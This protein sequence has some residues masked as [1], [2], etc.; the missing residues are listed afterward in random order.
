MELGKR[1]EWGGVWRS[2]GEPSEPFLMTGFGKKALHLE[3]APGGIMRGEVDFLGDGTWEKYEDLNVQG[4]KIHVFPN[5]FSAH[6]VRL[7]ALQAGRA[8]AEF[9]Y[10]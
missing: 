1:A 7:T 6:W 10:T 8:T 9:H 4:Y 3:L 5:G 2:A